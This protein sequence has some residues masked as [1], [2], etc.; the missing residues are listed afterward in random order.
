MSRPCVV[1]RSTTLLPIRIGRGRLKALM[2]K[3]LQ[4]HAINYNENTQ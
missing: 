4:K 2:T 3:T 1:L